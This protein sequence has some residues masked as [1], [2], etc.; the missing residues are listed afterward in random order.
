MENELFWKELTTGIY[1]W[2]IH[3]EGIE[4][5]LDNLQRIVGCNAAYML[6]LMHHE[7]RPPYENYYPHNPVR[8]FFLPEDSRAYWNVH[9][10]FYKESRI[11][12]RS[13]EVDFLRGTDWLDTFVTAVK[14]RG[15]KAGA[16]ITHTPL[17]V[18]RGSSE[19]SD[20]L[21][22]DIYG[23]PPPMKRMTN[24]QLCWNNPDSVAYLCSLCADLVS[25]YEIDMIQT[26]TLLFNTGT[27]SEHS[28]LGVA[29][30][31]C[32]CP[33]CEKEAKAAGLDWELIRRTVRMFADI[34]TGATLQASEALLLVRRGSASQ[35]MLL[36]EYPELYD[37]LKFRCDSITKFFRKVTTV[38]HGIRKDID[39]RFNTIWP[40]PEL[41][42]L[43]IRRIAPYINSFRICDY[44]EQTGDEAKV[45]AK[46]SWIADVRR[47]AGENVPIIAALA[48]RGKATVDLIRKAVKT[49]A[50]AG[51]DGL[52]FGFY[53]CATFERLA[54]IRIGMEEA[55]VTIR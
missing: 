3:D 44:A 46:G 24:Q 50:L 28:L 30:G 45:L 39:F 34:M 54:A 9:P 51:V 19:F 10:E 36:L 29:L 4:N 25:S 15:M 12:P 20:C 8:K 33:G 35:S 38:I 7:K 42:G 17:D 32:F 49:I 18:E 2:D 5:I 52:G 40:N 22:R 14:K 13:S 11:R 47:Q 43:D 16:Q 27:A 23:N 53:D 41:A 26:S 31:G 6:S 1:P 21:Q 55:E 37:W 48:P